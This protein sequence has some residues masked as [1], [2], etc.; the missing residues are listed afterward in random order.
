MHWLV[1]GAARKNEE[2]IDGGIALGPDGA[3]DRRA[4]FGATGNGT[5]P[6]LAGEL[7][8]VRTGIEMTHVPYKGG[9]PAI[10]DLV[11]GQTQLMF[12]TPIEVMQQVQAGRLKVLATTAPRRLP[13]QPDVPTVQESGYP[14][15]EVFAWF[16]VLAPAGTPRPVIDKLAGEFGRLVDLPDVKEKLATQSAIVQLKAGDEFA[17]FIAAEKTKWDA[18]V[19]ASGARID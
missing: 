13:T 4:R 2:E 15:F 9:G 18:V 19:K 12:A 16:G 11:G 6:H 7:F 10:T 5:V 14:G 8:K 3:A 1:C 17:A